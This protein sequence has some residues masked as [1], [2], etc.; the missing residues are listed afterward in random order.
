MKKKLFILSGVLAM[1][2]LLTFACKKKKDETIAPQYKADTGTGGNPDPNNIT[3]TGT[4]TFAPV[5]TENSSFYVG[6]AGWSNPSCI[7]T[8]SLYLKANNGATEVTVTFAFPPSVGT[9]TYQVAS[10]VGAQ[11]CVFTVLNAPG[12]P[13]D[14]MW[15]GRS[16]AIQVVST[17]TTVNASIIGSIRCE[18]SN[19]KFP[20]VTATGVLGCN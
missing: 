5:P 7:T 2:V 11:T 15:Y 16:G 8:N 14:I 17:G 19:F 9:T 20:A 12:Q 4:T 10:N 1:T 3:T 18:Q 13:A 6:G